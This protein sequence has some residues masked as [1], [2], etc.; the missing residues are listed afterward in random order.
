MSKLNI[1][2][3]EDVHNKKIARDERLSLDFLIY[4]CFST[5]LIF[6]YGFKSQANLSVISKIMNFRTHSSTVMH[7]NLISVSK[8]T[9][10][11]LDSEHKIIFFLDLPSILC[12][13]NNEINQTLN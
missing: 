3:S 10:W 8:V 4:L 5:N 2:S 13:N 6:L 1:C 9:E 12:A 11:I 7:W